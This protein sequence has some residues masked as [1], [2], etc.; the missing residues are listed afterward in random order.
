MRD[1]EIAT[2]KVIWTGKRAIDISRHP[3]PD[4]V[5]PIRILAGALA[6]NIPERDLRLSPEHAVYLGDNFY[7]AESLVNGVTVFQEQ[8]TTHVT[9][10]HIELETHVVLLAEGLACES[11]L[12]TGNKKMFA[13]VS[14]V[15]VLHPDFRPGPDALRCAPLVK[16]GAELARIRSA[17]AYR[18]RHGH[19]ALF[20]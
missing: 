1:N 7:T 3:A 12:D 5:R 19:V 8:N 18:A 9:Y 20:S 15:T 16:D 10:H 17:I 4:L 2:A 11:F 14:G 13:S 6:D